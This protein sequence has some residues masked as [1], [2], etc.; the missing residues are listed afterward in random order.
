MIGATSNIRERPTM[1]GATSNTRDRPTMVA[2][3]LCAASA[4]KLARLV[5]ELVSGR[6]L[7]HVPAH[8]PN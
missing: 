5:T 8:S 2:A 6:D 7:Y 4:A 1:I 3:S